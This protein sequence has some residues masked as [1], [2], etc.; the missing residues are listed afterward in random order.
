MRIKKSKSNKGQAI[1]LVNNISYQKGSIVSNEIVN[2]KNGT[3]TAF[4]FDKG[5]GLSEHSAPF[6]A[7]VNVIDGLANIYLAKKLFKVNKGQMLIMPA[8]I[9]HALKAV[10]KFKMI[11]TMIKEK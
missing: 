1:D 5:Q 7:V 8:N 10:K 4:A 6:D 3:I 9:P 2:K 11:L